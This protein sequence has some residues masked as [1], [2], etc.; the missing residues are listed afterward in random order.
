MKK[1]IFLFLTQQ[2]NL[3]GFLPNWIRRY[4][5]FLKKESQPVPNHRKDETLEVGLFNIL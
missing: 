2:K 3:T 1:G 4:S 5:D